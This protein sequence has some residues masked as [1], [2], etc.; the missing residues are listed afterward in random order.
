MQTGSVA[1]ALGTDVEKGL[2]LTEASD[3]LARVG[4]NELRERPPVPRW[5]RFVRHF[6]DPLVLL[7]VAAAAISLVVWMLEGTEGAP[8]ESLV[9]AAIVLLN[10]A[11]GYAQEAHAEQVVA[12]LRAMTET[13]ATVI[14][15]GRSM[16]IPARE[17]VPGDLMLIETGDAIAA[18]AR[19]VREVSLATGEGALTGESEPVSKDVHPVERDT[20]LGDR[21]SMVY[22]GTVVTFGRGVGVV[23]AT[24]MGTELGTIAGLLETVEEP[25]TPLQL[26]LARVGRVLGIAVVAVAAIVIG[27]LLATSEI[28][29]TDGLI[30]VLLIGVS[31]A[32]AAVPEGLATILTVVMALGVQRMARRHAIIRRLSAVETLG[33]ATTIC[34][35]KTGTLTRNEMTV[36]EVVTATGSAVLGGTGYQP[37][38]EITDADGRPLRE[39]PSREDIEQLLHAAALASNATL[40]ERDGAWRVYGDPTEGAL[41]TAAAKSGVAP[42]DVG[43]HLERI[44]EVPFSSQR[45]LMS[46]IHEDHQRPGLIH[47]FAKGAPDVL[48]ARCTHERRGGEIV[49]LS[50]DRRDAIGIV[51][52]ALASRAMRT[53]G[54]SERQL[55]ADAY[56]GPG[57]HLEQDLVFLGV[58]GMIDPAREEAAV[59]VA[60]AKGAGV[61]VIMIT[62]DHPITARAIAGEVEIA[63]AED[64]VV[65]GVELERMVDDEFDATVGTASVYARVSPEHKLRIVR[66]LQHAGDVVAMT[67]DGVNDAPALKTADIGVAMGITGTDVSKEASDMILTDDNFATIVAAIEE[68]RAIFAN[69]RKFIRYLLSSNTGEVLTMLLGILFAGALGL[70]SGA[71]GIVTPLL[72]VQILWINLLTDAAPALAVGVDPPELGAMRRPPRQR[73]A[74]VIDGPMWVSI[75]VNGFAMAAA[76]LFVADLVLPGG[77][78]EGTGTQELARTMAFTV[79][80]LAQLVNVFNSRSDRESAFRHLFSNPLLW[81]AV[82]LSASLQVAVIYLPFLNTAFG[83]EPLTAAQWATAIAGASVVLWVSEARKLVATALRP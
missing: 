50:A 51:I 74:R 68:G 36:R 41:I 79:L 15:E 65:T 18:D 78:V 20:A 77:L 38:G 1:Q 8:I 13:S 21:S 4:P 10:A 16:S 45:K 11:L 67:G 69:I 73:T 72:A 58:I 55:D 46:T 64:R 53:L 49:P 22:S 48:L 27:A 28:H 25:K 71:N 31:L 12:A 35:D 52:E 40:E 66:S 9:I 39:S 19:L 44:D 56:E 80:V 29:G 47:V 34:S 60:E 3:R 6:A 23:T 32:V 26:E 76:T 75:G 42:D 14:R 30:D 63:A 81:A 57:E 82:A 83:T 70:A 59:A 33:S 17:L 24:G 5:R 2:S 61:R 43:T 7:L 62:G 54:V 37:F